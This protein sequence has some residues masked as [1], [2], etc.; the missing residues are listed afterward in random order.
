[1]NEKKNS[2][3]DLI[4]SIFYEAGKRI[5]KPNNKK[6][7]SDY[8]SNWFEVTK[9]GPIGYKTLI[10]QYD[11]YVLKLERAEQNAPPTTDHLN[12]YARFLDFDNYNDYIVKTNEQEATGRASSEPGGASV[13]AIETAIKEQL[14]IGTQNNIEHQ[15]NIE[16]QFIGR[17]ENIKN[18][19]NIKEQINVH[20]ESK[21]SQKRNRIILFIVI[22][23]AIVTS[24]TLWY[25]NTKEDKKLCL[26]WKGNHF[27]SIV[28]ENA[29]ED[30]K[31]LM[32]SPNEWKET[33]KSFRKI[34]PSSSTHF[35]DSD[36]N[37]KVWYQ[38]KDGNYDF[39]NQ[40]GLHPETGQ[41]LLPVTPSVVD[42]YFNLL[43]IEE[44]DTSSMLEKSSNVSELPTSTDDVDISTEILE[45]KKGKYCFK[46]ESNQ[47]L[48]TYIQG[49]GQI[50][51]KII[52]QPKEQVCMFLPVNKYHFSTYVN[53][54]VD[55][56]IKKGDITV[57]ENK[58]GYITL[59]IPENN[60]ETKQPE[61]SPITT[62]EDSKPSKDCSKG[63]FC[64]KNTT[65]DVLNVRIGN[66]VDG[67]LGSNFY[68]HLTVQAQSTE[69]FYDIP[70]VVYNLQYHFN[71]LSLGNQYK[72][73]NI[74]VA[75]CETGEKVF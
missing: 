16:N 19:T 50:R 60:T 6:A 32:I 15:N 40:S 61:R 23:I 42:S 3:E 52:L 28:C 8:L 71:E 53:G 70:A 75:G 20:E 54:R 44:P 59:N 29:S 69:C 4:K 72:Y 5:G 74:K 67:P 30:E 66:K 48:E 45:E 27:E 31:D 47:T 14:N 10:R 2:I 11:R 41:K 25:I 64:I 62:N 24:I 65:N 7:M 39:F 36:G 68:F 33:Y 12:A 46:N 17:Q 9:N 37:A 63:D 51:E 38:Y 55:T 58:E 56:P 35:F 22:F 13:A 1:M 43:Q 73:T 26:F 49:P 57:S 21:E 18:Q 34:Q